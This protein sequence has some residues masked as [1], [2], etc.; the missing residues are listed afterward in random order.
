M[1]K[2]TIGEVILGTLTIVCLFFSS[3]CSTKSGIP[4]D[5]K[6]PII[7]KYGNTQFKITF[8]ATNLSS[9]ISD[10]YYS[11]KNMPV[12]PS[13]E[14]VGYVFAGWYFDSALTKVC[15][16]ENGDLYWQ[17]KNITLY[18]KWEK[19][20]IVNNGTYD[21]DFEAK[22]IDD[23]V[24]KGI[25]ADKYGWYNFADDIIKDETYIEKNN[26]GTYL[27]IQYNCRERGPIFSDGGGGE[28]EVQTYTI[29]DSE[30]RI[31][32]SL[33]IL[34]RTSL[35]QTIYYDISD[36]NLEDEII[37]NIA[38][39]NWGAKLEG[40]E[41]REQCSVSYK[42]SFKITR[43][44]G[45]SKSFINTEGKL[46]N[47]VYLVPT[48]YTGLDK[49][50]G[51]LDYFHPVYAYLIAEN[52]HYSLVKPLSA[53][54]SDIFGNLSGDDFFN[55]STGYCRDFT[56]FLT[57][58]KNVVSISGDDPK[59][60]S[61]YRPGLLDAKSWGEL[62]YEFH[63]DTGAYYYTFDL[64]ESL[65]NDII[66][67]GG[68]TGAME[69]M[70]NF[71]FTYRRLTISYDSM[72]RITDWDYTPIEG[73]SFTYK[74]DA[75]IYA[76][77]IEDFSDSNAPF[78]LLR[79]YNLSIRM[80]NM[81]FSS[82]DGGVTGE[83]NY[84]CKMKIAPTSQTS[85]KDLSEMRYSFSYF[86]LTYDVFDYDA[87]ND[88]ELYSAATN[89][90]TLI[91]SS[92]TNFTIEKT[93]IGKT[94][95]VG[96]TIDLYTL[97]TEKVYPTVNSSLLSW[98]AYS[99]DR[100]GNPNYNNKVTLNRTFEMGNNGVAILFKEKSNEKTR[101]CLV[102]L[103][104]KDKV[105]YKINS[106]YWVYDE[107]EKVYV[108]NKRFKLD[109]YAEVPE[110]TWTTLGETY[111][112]QSLKKYDDS[113]PRTDFLK[114]AVYEY[115]DG[116][117]KHVFNQF[118][119]GYDL[120]NAINM[121]ESKMRVEFR[122]TNK[123]GEFTSIFF[124]YRGEA[125]GDYAFISN[126]EVISNGELDYQ[127]QEDGTEIRAKVSYDEVQSHI[128]DN[129]KDFKEIPTSYR[130]KINDSDITSD[131]ELK[132]S[133][134]TVY[135]KTLTKTVKT[136]D[137]AW[138]LIKDDS[139]AVIGL[140]YLDEYGD[141]L[142]RKAMYNFKLDGNPLGYYQ[143]VD[144]DAAVFTG[145]HISLEKAKIA[146][147]DNQPLT[148]AYFQVY[149]QNGVN[150]SR[151]DDSEL[152]DESTT[153]GAEFTFLKEGT[154]LLVWYFGFGVDFNNEPILDCYHNPPEGINS[155]KY[156]LAS[157]FAQKI[158]VY[159]ENCDI[160]LTYVTDVEH[161]FDETKVDYMEKD[162][163]QYY[164]TTV[165]M[166][167]N[168][169]SLDYG[170]FKKSADTLWGWSSSLN[171]ANGDNRLFSSS[172]SMGKLGITLSSINPVIYA[173]WDKGINISATIVVDE[174]EEKLGTVLYHRP[175]TG[176]TYTMTL[177]DF[178]KWYD[179][180]KYENYEAVEWQAS[181]PIFL[182]SSSAGFNYFD[183]LTVGSTSKAFENGYRVNEEFSLKLI[184]KRKLNV[185]YQAIDESFNK[186][187]FVTQPTADR[188]CL[189]GY[190]LK[191]KIA[192]SKLNLLNNVKCSDINKVFKYWAVKV[193]GTLLKIDLE[194]TKLEQRFSSKND[195][196]NTYTG[197]VVLYAVFGEE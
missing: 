165:S 110:V 188:N 178:R 169:L 22:I 102:T 111:T 34:D 95:N 46:D 64:G 51:M 11:A 17:M 81:F 15:D 141:S 59:Y 159:D 9:P 6:D 194:E 58:Q 73:D 108:T 154:Y 104:P 131:N 36:L 170:S 38:Y 20:A 52:G 61:Y 93:N 145:Q 41:T 19:E 31:D 79:N 168:N 10:M 86:N 173:L 70:F 180:E 33:N 196:T 120:I 125:V 92:A 106:S 80:I 135:T 103:M 96:D 4:S 132:L 101:S 129:E 183:V 107:E 113:I 195:Q 69:Q 156:T 12:L 117:Y 189:E 68:S 128:V 91:D 127:K 174:R 118:S 185:S 90:L 147:S 119:N 32:E 193:D 139:Y 28:F 138:N 197:S 115:S 3:S 23:S 83:K 85:S 25:L 1:K 152:K 54:N 186:L 182:D 53:Y 157:T 142:T 144:G 109:S 30:N 37:L 172:A 67:Y 8:D 44:I 39:Y 48:H 60:N 192:S 166:A 50:L 88:G 126:N 45:F 21:I 162:G 24:A 7:E 77:P 74:K 176:G 143:F 89:F 136:L 62:T 167:K 98:E 27:R 191:D 43:F 16:V 66:L 94:V 105:D 71:P 164:T 47:G 49:T 14:K 35:I 184:L 190:T 29:T 63:A 2:K 148:R 140:T 75:A 87:K 123:F 72:I 5:P 149:K 161:P 137:E 146:S 175:V 151:T 57:N 42:V 171:D 163:Y 124:E 26:Q 18:P 112:S 55:R 40:D 181:K 65:D 100:N 158:T 78:D 153:Y 82:N 133:S 150:Y 160:S 97:Y 130:L 114:V 56:Y 177:F 134:C 179:F 76:G 121:S 13:P 84:D 122:L 116:I 187:S 99:L 155:N